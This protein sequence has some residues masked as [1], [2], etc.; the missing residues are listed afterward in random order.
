VWEAN[1]ESPNV[2]TASFC[3]SVGDLALIN[4]PYSN[5]QAF[6]TRPMYMKLSSKGEFREYLLIDI[7]KWTSMLTFRISWPTCVKSSIA[8]LHVC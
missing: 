7:P 5:F 6:G 4:K 1:K 8:Y 2:E 3:P